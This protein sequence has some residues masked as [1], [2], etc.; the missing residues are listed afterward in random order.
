MATPSTTPV[1]NRGAR[2]VVLQ[3]M[4][5]FVNALANEHGWNLFVLYCSVRFVWQ[6]GLMAEPCARDCRL[7][8]WHILNILLGCVLL[9]NCVFLGPPAGCGCSQGLS[10]E[11]GTDPWGVQLCAVL[12]TSH[13]RWVQPGALP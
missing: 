11:D 13:L 8:V 4:D 9:W 12:G 7:D 10:L 2:V 1:V 3:L 5:C 6:L